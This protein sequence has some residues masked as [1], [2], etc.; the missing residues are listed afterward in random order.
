MTSGVVTF[1]TLT[2]DAIIF[3][4]ACVCLCR[5]CTRVDVPILLTVPTFVIALLAYCCVVFDMLGGEYASGVF[6]V[7]RWATLPAACCATGAAVLSFAY[8]TSR[9]ERVGV[10]KLA[11]RA[12]VAASSTAALLLTACQWSLFA[13][14]LYASQTLELAKIPG[15]CG[16]AT[17]GSGGG[18]FLSHA[19]DARAAATMLAP[20]LLVE[21]TALLTMAYYDGCRANDAPR[22]NTAENTRYYLSFFVMVSVVSTTLAPARIPLQHFAMLGVLVMWSSAVRWEWDAKKRGCGG[23]GSR[24][25]RRPRQPLLAGAE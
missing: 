1:A 18:V 6:C 11:E 3:T 25:P 20:F 2:I 5:V 12:A 9:T 17:V 22:R 13:R 8:W 10:N 14:D 24:R 4:C 23:W 16:V 15:T 21:M 19:V 7:V